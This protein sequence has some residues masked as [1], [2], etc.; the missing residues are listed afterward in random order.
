M[1]R[2]PVA[3]RGSASESPVDVAAAGVLS[4]G[5]REMSGRREDGEA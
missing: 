5:S 2:R 1:P 3:E 4:Y